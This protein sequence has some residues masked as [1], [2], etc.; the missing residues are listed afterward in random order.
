MLTGFTFSD[1]AGRRARR[2]SGNAKRAMAEAVAIAISG[3]STI[4]FGS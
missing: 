1:D 2:R 4:P 3:A